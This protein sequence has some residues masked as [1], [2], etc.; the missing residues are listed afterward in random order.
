[1]KS[2]TLFHSQLK[3]V[4]RALEAWRKTR[5]P[6]QPIPERLWVEMAI[7]A[8]THG[9]SSVSKA[10]RLDYYTLKRRVSEPEPVPAADFVEVKFAPTV[11]PPRGCT[12]ELEDHQGRKL[13][14]RWSSAPGPELLGVVQAF[15]N[16]SV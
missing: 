10:L 3:P 4:R 5:R 6:R 16:Q 13:V 2:K 9:V 1:M 11:D 8:R 12:A 15:W 14:L 7:L